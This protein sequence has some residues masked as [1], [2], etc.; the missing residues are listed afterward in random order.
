M[1]AGRDGAKAIYRKFDDQCSNEHD[2]ETLCYPCTLDAL[3]AYAA[4]K[5]GARQ[6]W[7]ISLVEGLGKIWK[8]Q[9]GEDHADAARRIVEAL[10]Q[11]SGGEK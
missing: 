9:G 5:V 6:D 11:A 2:T 1:S 4:E 8:K 10:K 3:E 7:I